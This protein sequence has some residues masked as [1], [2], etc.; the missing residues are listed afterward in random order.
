MISLKPKLLNFR[1]ID[2]V[3]LTLFGLVSN[4]RSDLHLLSFSFC[5]QHSNKTRLPI[6]HFPHN[7]NSFLF[8]PEFLPLLQ[9]LSQHSPLFRIIP[10]FTTFLLLDSLLI[11][12]LIFILPDDNLMKRKFKLAGFLLNCLNFLLDFFWTLTI[13]SWE[14]VI[15][16]FVFDSIWNCQL[17]MKGQIKGILIGWESFTRANERI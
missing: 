4:A 14:Q 8:F 10:H 2:R 12:F 3:R 7:Q 11:K 16:R 9:Q 6:A 1:F 5:C 17:F 13:Q 15:W